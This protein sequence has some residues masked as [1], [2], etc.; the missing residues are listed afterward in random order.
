MMISRLQV[1]D[2]VDICVVDKDNSLLNKFLF[3]CYFR[4]KG[5]DITRCTHEKV[6][7]DIQKTL[8]IVINQPTKQPVH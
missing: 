1:N 2:M 8:E 4:V 3:L 7:V 5:A 6:R